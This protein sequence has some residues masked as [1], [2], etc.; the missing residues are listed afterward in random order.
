M[1][2]ARCNTTVHTRAPLTSPPHSSTSLT[3]GLDGNEEM[4]DGGN[5]ITAL[6]VTPEDWPE[7]VDIRERLRNLLRKRLGNEWTF[8][9]S[10]EDVIF[11]GMSVICMRSDW[12][13][14]DWTPVANTE[15]S[16]ADRLLM[17]DAQEKLTA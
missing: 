10:R 9:T 7:F 13:N 16:A 8:L 3:H 5:G 4:S 15:P 12:E 6:I 11:G 14:P 2:P 1:A 17:Q